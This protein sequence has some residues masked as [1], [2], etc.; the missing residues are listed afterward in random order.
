MPEPALPPR[1]RNPYDK[2]SRAQQDEHARRMIDEEDHLL[3]EEV[4]S[5]SPEIAEKIDELGI[6]PDDEMDDEDEEGQF[7][8]METNPASASTKRGYRTGVNVYK[9]F[10]AA[11]KTKPLDEFVIEDIENKRSLERSFRRFATFLH[12][13]RNAASGKHY[14]PDTMTSYLSNTFSFLGRKFPKAANL[15]DKAVSATNVSC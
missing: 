6:E 13:Y 9:L 2:A 1:V 3:S 5:L 10:A 12:T 7:V 15:K 14:A 11:D 4:P 8:A